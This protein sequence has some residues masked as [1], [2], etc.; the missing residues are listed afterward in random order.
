MSACSCVDVALEWI[1][2]KWGMSSITGCGT[3][4]GRGLST[5]VSWCW[6][7]DVPWN[8]RLSCCSLKDVGAG[9]ISGLDC[10]VGSWPI[11]AETLLKPKPTTPLPVPTCHKHAAFCRVA[12]IDTKECE[13]KFQRLRWKVVQYGSWW[14]WQSLTRA[15]SSSSIGGTD[16]R[17]NLPVDTGLDP[18]T[19]S[20]AKWPKS[21]CCLK[22]T[23]LSNQANW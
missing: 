17:L 21:L 2:M 23:F 14:H 4:R 9:A 13:D 5:R 12:S 16:I 1:R 22:R 11:L 15:L 10:Y 6:C 3:R 8:T 7:R 18:Q 19:N 20:V